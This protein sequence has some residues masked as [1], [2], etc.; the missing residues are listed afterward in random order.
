MAEP[1]R[2]MRRVSTLI[3]GIVSLLVAITT[4]VWLASLHIAYGT[5][6]YDTVQVLWYDEFE[7]A[8]QARYQAA[9]LDT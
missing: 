3:T 4:P 6:E 7:S 5:A 2:R 9:E 8:D 1:G